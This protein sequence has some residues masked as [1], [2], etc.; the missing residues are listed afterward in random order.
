VQFR[1]VG[2]PHASSSVSAIR[3]GLGAQTLRDADDSQLVFTPLTMDTFSAG[4]TR[5][6]RAVYTVTNN[7]GAALDHLTFVP[8]NTDPDPNAST[9]AS[10]TPTVGPTYFKSLTRFDGSDTSAHAADLTPITGM[11]YSTA[12]GAAI[13]D[14]MPYTA[15]RCSC[16]WLPPDW[17]STAGRTSV[18]AATR[19]SPPGTGRASPSQSPSRTPAR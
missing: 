9:P 13:T 3:A 17:S 5:Y 8:V 15:P 16:Q 12:Q 10:T 2:S 4:T 19:P 6:V 11:I 1:G 14:A 7:T 18:G